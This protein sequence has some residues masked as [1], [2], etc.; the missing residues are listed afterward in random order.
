MRKQNIIFRIISGLFLVFTL[1]CNEQLDI[2][3]VSSISVASFWESPDD[4]RGAL[5]GV[6]TELRELGNNYFFMGELRSGGFMGAPIRNPI[7]FLEYF[8]NRLT[9]AN[10]NMGWQQPYKV[11]SSVNLIIANVPDIVFPSELEQNDILAQAYAIRAY[12]YFI[13]ARTWGDVP[14]IQ[15]PL[16]DFDSE[17]TFIERSSVQQI[18]DLIKADI[19]QS[20]ALFPDNEFPTGRSH[21]SKPAANMLKG[22]VYLW[23]GKQ[24][25]GGTQDFTTALA[26]FE[27]VESTGVQLLENYSEIFD[28]EN[29][30]N[31][32]I[33]FAIH[34]NELETG[35]NFYYNTYS[36]IQTIIS[37][38][39]ETREKLLPGGWGVLAPATHIMDQYNDE[40]TRK[41]ATFYKIYAEDDGA[42]VTSSLIKYSGLVVAGNRMFI[43]DIIIYRYADLLLLKA[44]AK[45]ALGQDPSTE[46]NM[47]RERA[48]G[49]NYDQHVFEAGT[50]EENDEAILQERLFEL[51]WEGTRWWDLVRFGKAYELVP[52]LQGR[53]NEV[54]LLFPLPEET[55]SRN[56]TLTQTP[57]Y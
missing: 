10:A 8:E 48:Y 21:W 42:F 20:I 40:D 30:G 26:A 54:P 55:L 2:A 38:D 17:S 23:T 9:A 41:D 14:L 12:M 50:Q 24:M 56:S 53:Q 46:M 7:G 1:S 37:G 43:D 5:A 11:I 18:F 45:N 35:N 28:F 51:G 4:V 15:D 32:E 52:S 27:D 39:E 16:S 49:E 25:G 57:G 47:I 19:D 22:K 6:Y 3:P 36:Q 31:Q 13:L 34:F 44:E 33:I 29:K